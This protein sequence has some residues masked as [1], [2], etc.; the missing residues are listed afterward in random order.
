MSN[1]TRRFSIILP[2]HNGEN[3]LASAIESVLAQSYPHFRLL[4]L[5]NAST[6]RT[7][8]IIN[9]YRDARI[10]VLPTQQLLSIE[11]NWGRDA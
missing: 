4:I 6:D 2:V 5:E 8:E 11:Q 3:Y 9:T 7:R 1:P 10:E